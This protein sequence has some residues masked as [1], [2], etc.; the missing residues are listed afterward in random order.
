M[1]NNVLAV[2][3]YLPQILRAGLPQLSRTHRFAARFLKD[4]LQADL[5]RAK[6]GCMLPT[7]EMSPPKPLLHVPYGYVMA[8]QFSLPVIA[9]SLCATL[10]I[11]LHFEGVTATHC[12]VRLACYELLYQ[13]CV[14]LKL[15]V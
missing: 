13:W 5:R 11:Y 1:L 8:V 12:R 7:R 15:S 6:A 4:A 9:L 2:I 10:G 14:C 3:R